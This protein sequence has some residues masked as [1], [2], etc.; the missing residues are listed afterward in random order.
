MLLYVAALPDD[1]DR[2]V[3][4]DER[5]DQIDADVRTVSIPEHELMP[6]LRES[7]GWAGR[8]QSNRS[9]ALRHFLLRE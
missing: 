9:D 2:S 6:A 4:R 3:S 7:R 1:S 5:I 8:G